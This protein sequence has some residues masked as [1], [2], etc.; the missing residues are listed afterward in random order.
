VAGAE[1]SV[2]VGTI[3]DLI[4]QGYMFIAASGL[5]P[6]KTVSIPPYGAD[7]NVT[8]QV[9]ALYLGK[10]NEFVICNYTIVLSVGSVDAPPPRLTPHSA[11]Y[12]IK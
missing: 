12:K 10:Q 4:S 3:P 1:V 5:G 9:G 11:C 6:E 7:P 8:F 2:Q